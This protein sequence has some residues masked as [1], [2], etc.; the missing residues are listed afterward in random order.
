MAF[1]NA[2]NPTNTLPFT[3]TVSG[4]QQTQNHITHVTKTIYFAYVFCYIELAVGNLLFAMYQCR[5]KQLPLDSVK[6]Y[7]VIRSIISHDI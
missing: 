1:I 5:Y 6:N 3:S 2:A 4:F 7:K